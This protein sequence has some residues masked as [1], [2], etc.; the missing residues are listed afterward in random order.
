MMSVVLE[1]F[2]QME[3]GTKDARIERS[4]EPG[5]DVI[6]EQSPGFLTIN[7]CSFTAQLGSLSL[8]PESN[9]NIP[10]FL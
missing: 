9:P 1:A 6:I 7:S 2:L 4:K 5:L 3:G 10:H 8:S